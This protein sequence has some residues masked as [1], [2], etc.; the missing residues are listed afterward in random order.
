V[1]LSFNFIRATDDNF[2]DTEEL[3]GLEPLHALPNGTNIS[4]NFKLCN[5]NY[6][7]DNL[8]VCV[9]TIAML[10]PEKN[11]HMYTLIQKYL[12]RSCIIYIKRN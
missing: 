7:T 10:R 2:D 6:E 1:T 5:E 11:L 8:T 4:Q 12:N 3:P 9:L